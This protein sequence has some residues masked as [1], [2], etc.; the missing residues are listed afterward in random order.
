MSNSLPSYY[1]KREYY[2]E[3]N[4]EYSKE[5]PEVNK[6]ACKKYYETHKEEI[7]ERR[8]ASYDPEKAKLKRNRSAIKIKARKAVY[9]AIRFGKLKKQPC[10]SCG[11]SKVHGH[12]DD[13]NKP[14]EV[15]WLCQKHHDQ[16]HFEF[17]RKD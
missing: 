12:H 17:Q 11:E 15:R 2:I 9:H 13:Y 10:E 3:K 6:K 7:A 5:H 16:Y 1:K 4:K 14:L 8:R